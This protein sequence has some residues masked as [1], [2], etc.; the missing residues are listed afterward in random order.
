MFGIAVLA[1]MRW[2]EQR[3]RSQLMLS[4]LCAL[5][6]PLLKLEGAVWL[7]LFAGMV[8]YGLVPQRW[9]KYFVGSVVLLLIVGIAIGRLMLPLFGLGWVNI[10]LDAV[11]IPVLGR[12]AIEWHSGAFTSVVSSLFARSNWHLLWWLVP[13]LVAWRWRQLPASESLRLPR[14]AAAGRFLFSGVPVP[15]DRC[16]TLGRELYRDQPPGD[17]YHACRRHAAGIVVSRSGFSSSNSR[18]S[19]SVSSTVRSRVNSSR[20]RRLP[21][22]PRRWRSFTSSANRCSAFARASASPGGTSKPVSPSRTT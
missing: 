18:Y 5:T 12:L 9:R 20:Q 3:D 16:G 22:S 21:A 19:A 11:D 4:F 7:L 10:G 15:A 17:A 8:G 2:L 6:L 14:L 1:W 13:V